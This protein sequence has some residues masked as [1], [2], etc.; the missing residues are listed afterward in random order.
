MRKPLRVKECY[1][2]C[3]EKPR[4]DR[5]AQFE[6]SL[7]SFEGP[8]PVGTSA[9]NWNLLGSARSVLHS[10]SLRQDTQRAQRL[11]RSRDTIDI[12]SICRGSQ[13]CWHWR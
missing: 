2:I 4:R 3:R 7:G 10:C 11:R 6:L 8:S 12:K 13:K 1:P 9:R 5:A